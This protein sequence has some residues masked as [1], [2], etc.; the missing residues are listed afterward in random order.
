MFS[1]PLCW[2]LPTCLAL[3]APAAAQPSKKPVPAAGKSARPTGPH[4]IGR[5]DDWTAAVHQEAGRTVCYAFTRATHSAPA[6]PGRGEVVLTVTERDTSR[7]VVAISAGFAYT[8]NAAVSVTADAAGFEFYT[9]QRSAF[10]RDGHAAVAA[11][12]KGRQ[13]VARSPGPKSLPV[14]D[15]FS[16]LGFS[17]AY[18]A[19][20]KAC[21]VP[22]KSS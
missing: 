15:T 22:G 2:L 5:F 1:R 4:A 7:D 13:V 8:Q 17:A 3:A 21:P 12:Q 14:S 9:A 11:F 18:S 16:L 10:A 20:L 6:I 19:I